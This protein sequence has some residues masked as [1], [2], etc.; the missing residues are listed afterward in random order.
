[1]GRHIA[2]PDSPSYTRVRKTQAVFTGGKFLD[3]QTAF[4]LLYDLVAVSSIKLTSVF[5]HK[6]AIRTLFHR[7]TNHGYHILSMSFYIKESTPLGNPAQEG[8]DSLTSQ[9]LALFCALKY[10]HCQAKKNTNMKIL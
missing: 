2:G 5:F 3:F 1:V 6:K 4:T 9:K 10:K 7:C 8:V